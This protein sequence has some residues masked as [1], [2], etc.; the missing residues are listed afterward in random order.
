MTRTLGTLAL[1][2]VAGGTLALSGCHGRCGHGR[3]PARMEQAFTSH[4]EDVLDDLK[5]TPEQRA[6][7]LAVK[8]RI[9]TEAR[10]L[11]R[12]REGAKELVAQWDA[13]TPDVARVHALIDERAE[14][15]RAFA[16]HAA[17]G[18][19]E[20]HG[21]LTPEQREQVSKKLHRRL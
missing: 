9:A 6:R 17:D 18:L 2:A 15:W 8:E 16:R 1:V 7:I 19:A 3:D 5:A 13:A 14:A 11:H 21:V 12:G 4:V 20:V 10:G